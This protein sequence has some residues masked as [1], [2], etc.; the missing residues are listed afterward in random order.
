[1]AV[2]TPRCRRPDCIILPDTP[3]WMP[4]NRE[5]TTARGGLKILGTPSVISLHSEFL[6]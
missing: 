4:F 3:P 5:L 2:L 6:S 1:M